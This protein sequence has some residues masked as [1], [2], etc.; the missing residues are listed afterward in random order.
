MLPVT[1]NLDIFRARLFER[2]G[3][4]RY[5]VATVGDASSGFQTKPSAG[6]LDAPGV[7]GR[8]PF[9]ILV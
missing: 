8:R 7:S 2:A 1:M 3:P 6:A 5:G 9:K 4:V